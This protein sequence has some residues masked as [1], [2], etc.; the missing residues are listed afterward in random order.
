MLIPLRSMK[1]IFRGLIFCVIVIPLIFTIFFFRAIFVI[2]AT[3]SINIWRHIMQVCIHINVWNSALFFALLPS[4]AFNQ[5]KWCISCN[6]IHIVLFSGSY[7]AVFEL[8]SHLHKLVWWLRWS[9]YI[10]LFFHCSSMCA[11]VRHISVSHR[12]KKVLEGI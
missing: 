8:P 3:D 5:R 12:R 6:I 9:L 7:T 11:K 2:A 4:I 1:M 10:R